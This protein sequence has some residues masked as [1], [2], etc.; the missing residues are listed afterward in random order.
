M[1]QNPN[2][3]FDVVNEDDEVIGVR[4]RIDVHA[5]GLLHR[6]VHIHVLNGKGD[7][8]IQQRA[9]SKDVA[10]GKWTTACSGHVDAGETYETAAIRE[11]YEEL[12]IDV[13]D[14]ELVRPILKLPA[15]LATD[16]EFIWVYTY[17]LEGTF[18]TNRQEIE[19]TCWIK[20]DEL[21]GW[22][23]R[24]PNDFA[25]SFHTVWRSSRDYLR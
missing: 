3:K 20:L 12:H 5:Q 2:E 17:E 21:N 6:A 10:P 8:L 9:M 25:P 19:E 4:S 24:S 23:H 13:S 15:S 7:V 14:P 16:N 22:V 11:L 18:K 1:S